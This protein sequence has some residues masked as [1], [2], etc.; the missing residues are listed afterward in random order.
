[1]LAAGPLPRRFP[2][3]EGSAMPELNFD[4]TITKREEMYES[5]DVRFKDEIVGLVSITES[6]FAIHFY[7]PFANNHFDFARGAALAKSDVMATAISL[8]ADLLFSRAGEDWN[9]AIGNGEGHGDQQ[10]V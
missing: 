4:T 1:M 10:A 5:Y 7:G 6:G 3:H 2:V 9:A 8:V